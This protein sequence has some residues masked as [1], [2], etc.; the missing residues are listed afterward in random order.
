MVL[1]LL[2]KTSAAVRRPRHWRGVLRVGVMLDG[3]LTGREI[4]VEGTAG[5]DAFAVSLADLLVIE[6]NETLLTTAIARLTA[7]IRANSNPAPIAAGWKAVAG[8]HIHAA[9]A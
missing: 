3:R 6:A 2:W 9:L 1:R 8:L 5:T 7:P 4:A